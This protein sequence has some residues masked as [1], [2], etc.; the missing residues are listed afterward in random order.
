MRSFV[1]WAYTPNGRYTKV[2]VY[3]ENLGDA[4]LILVNRGYRDFEFIREE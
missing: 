4:M 3:A 1:F 2:R